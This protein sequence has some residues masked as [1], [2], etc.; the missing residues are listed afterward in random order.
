M[1]DAT[2]SLDEVLHSLKNKRLV[3]I[4]T[5]G[6]NTQ[7]PHSEAQLQMLESVS[8]RLK[9]LLVVSCSSQR[10]VVEQAYNAYQRLGLNGCVLSKMDES[11]SLGEAISLI[12]EKRLPVTYVT[13]GQRIPDD[14]DVA[15]KHELV[16]RAV[17]TAQRAIE[18]EKNSSALDSVYK[19]G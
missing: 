13:D 2:N 5:A 3:L 11:G 12:V 17:I 6:L 16:S 10:R 18:V 1:V 7:E 4:D 19:T 14:I 8:L 9:K 15:K